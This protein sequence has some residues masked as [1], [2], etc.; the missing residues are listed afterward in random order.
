MKYVLPAI[1]SVSHDSFVR[2]W[3]LP[4][5][6][7]SKMGIW[8]HIFII[9]SYDLNINLTQPA[10]ACKYIVI[11]SCNNDVI[12]SSC[13]KVVTHAQL[14]KLL[15][16]QLVTNLLSSITLNNLSASWEAVGTHST[17][18]N[19]LEQHWHRIKT[20]RKSTQPKK[21]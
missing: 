21:A 19:L 3:A 16:E 10:F 11:L 8:W 18:N 13:Y 17:K 4:K 15:L 12:L 5:H 6:S 9:I 7:S 14:V 1:I 2:V 20:H